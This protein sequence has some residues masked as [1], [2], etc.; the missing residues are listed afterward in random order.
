MKKLVLFSLIALPAVSIAQTPTQAPTQPE[1]TRV[2]SSSQNNPGIDGGASARA[3]ATL[4]MATRATTAP[5]LDGKTD[6][7]A[8]QNAQ[9]IDQFLQYQPKKGAETRFKTEV[10]ITYDDKYIYVLGRMYD[11]APDSIVSLLSR[12]DVRTASEQLK[13]V[14]DSYHDRRTG[15]EFCVNPAGVKRDY[16]VYDDNNEDPTWDGIWDVATKVDSVGWVAE[17]R[18][19]FSQLRFGNSADHTFG[20]LVVR[21]VAR[22]SERISWPLYDNDKQG[23]ISQLGEL[24]GIRDLAAVRRLEVTPYVVTKNETRPS[25]SSFNHPQS[26]SA[27]ADI[28]YGLSS[29][30]TLDATINP[31]FGQV[32]A[33]P[34][35]L[36]LSAF[37]QFFEER[38]PFFLEG[39]GIFSFRTAC[40][41][42][43]TQCTGLFYSRR[44]GR[45]PQLAGVYG[46]ASSPMNTTILSAAKVGGRLGRGLSVGFLD[47]VTQREQGAQGATIEPQTNYAVARLQQ[48]VFGGS[49]DIGAMVTGTN[50][51]MDAQSSPYLRSGAYT[52][53]IDVRKRFFNKNYELTGYIAGSLVRGTAA[54]IA[55]TQL[56]GVHRYQRP[57]DKL[58]FDPNRTSLSGN[59]ERLTISKFGGG[60][61]RFQS[62]YQRFSP[63]FETND[64]G[65]QPRADEQMFRNWLAFQF[66]NP[67]KVYRAAFFNFNTFQTWTTEGL[68]TNMSLNTNWHVQFPNQWWGHIGGNFGNFKATYADREARGGPAV[69]RSTDYDMWS[70]IEL[71][72]RKSWTPNMFFGQYGGDAG[73]SVGRWINPA[74]DLRMTSRFSTSLGFNYEKATN[75]NQ[76]NGNFGVSGVDTTHYTFARLNQ[77]TLSLTSR[78]NFTASPSLSLQ[79]YAQPFITTGKYTDWRE[80]ANPRAEKY[81]DRYKPYLGGD[82]GGFDFKQ[83]RSNTVVRWEYRPGS[84]LFFVWQ[85]GRELS[86]DVASDFN[87]GHDFKNLFSLHPNNTLLIKASYW[88]NP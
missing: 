37:E 28:K 15:F 2:A 65:F 39:A 32:E 88:F 41:D 12:R 43:D 69:R 5:V 86:S 16:Y 38:R 4:A 47:A 50:R 13:I 14:I 73:H 84:T 63:G 80:L 25:A 79:F 57:D 35:V 49:G 3:T 71:D 17:F 29:N 61:T 24:S 33:D 83:L 1:S 18:I 66:N 36:N 72:S 82:P 51:S 11:P 85:Q 59:A 48:S 62:V 81:E 76:W 21:D 70:G 26:L 78:M 20:L 22:T 55:S 87:F 58:S 46:D 56:D 60:V 40:G 7:P 27:G 6:D 44:V 34:A 30:L 31:D 9:V 74:I 77:T 42:I 10:R 67:S 45:S 53:G 68:P 64:V 75:D 19:P 54:A 23:Y 52:G 8:W